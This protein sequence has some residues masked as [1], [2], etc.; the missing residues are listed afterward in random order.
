MSSRMDDEACLQ[1]LAAGGD[2]AF[3]VLFE[4]HTDSVYNCAFRRTANWSAAEDITE[5]VFL[6]LWRQ[7]RRV[8]TCSGSIRPWLLGVAANQSR[9]W[10]RDN[11]RKARAVERLAGRESGAADDLADLVASRIDDERRMAGLLAAVQALPAPQQDVLTLWV[12][13]QLSYDEIAAALGLRVGTVK[14]RLSRARA[15]LAGAEGTLAGLRASP[16]EPPH[17][18]AAAMPPGAEQEGRS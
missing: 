17:R 14:S 13:E 15:A 7:R 1:A 2:Q 6:E 4:R 18:A 3:G 9:R 16:A 10:W 11:A 12:W 8:V 5:S